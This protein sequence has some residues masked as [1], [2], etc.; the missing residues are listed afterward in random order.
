MVLSNLCVGLPYSLIEISLGLRDGIA[1]DVAKV[2]EAGGIAEQKGD[3]IGARDIKMVCDALDC[4]SADQHLQH[5]SEAHPGL[6]PGSRPGRGFILPGLNLPG[7][8]Q[9][10][11]F[12]ACDLDAR[13]R[14][15]HPHAERELTRLAGRQTDDKHLV[16]K[17]D[18]A[19]PQEAGLADLV[20]R[21][22]D[23]AFEVQVAVVVSGLLIRW[24][25][26]AQVT[27]R[28]V[29]HEQLRNTHHR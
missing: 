6:I 1:T 16:R 21:I 8:V 9:A 15:V 2:L 10:P 14:G 24:E 25:V 17:G 22:G 26:Q 5:R 28:L 19:L 23:R 29:R 7:K 3:G 11:V 20:H 18:E 13:L 27:E 4:T 12:A